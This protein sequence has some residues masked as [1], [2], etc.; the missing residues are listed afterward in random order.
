MLIVSSISIIPYL[1]NK[2]LFLLSNK[3]IGILG[4]G[5]LGRMLI[6]QG[7]NYGMQTYVL[8]KDEDAP[9]VDICTKFHRGNLLDEETVFTFGAS[10]DAI[11]I[12][13]EHVNVEALVLLEQLGKMVIPSSN[14][15]S[16]IKNK[17]LQKQFYREK[18]IPTADFR[19]IANRAELLENEDFFPAFLKLNELGYDGKGVMPIRSEAD[20]IDA[21]DQPALLEKFVDFD[22][23]I[24]VIVVRN[25]V[26]EMVVYPVVECV[27]N[28]VYNL[29]DYLISPARITEEL[30][31]KAQKIAL[32]VVEGLRSPGIFAVEMFLQ[33]DGTILVNETAPRAH[34]SGHQTI[35]G[36]FSSQFDQQARLL[37]GLPFGSTALKSMS[38]MINLV[39]E[40]GYTGI[41]VYEGLEEVMK[42]EG[43]FLHLYGKTETRPGR[44]M[45]HITIVGTKYEDLIEKA[46]FIRQHLKIKA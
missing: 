18:N 16:I 5:Q 35:E 22:K 11:I 29:V 31:V 36:N 28:P 15:L 6:Q 10:L 25:F 19:W 12:E 24:S 4:G 26:G 14:A 46:N 33:N 30:Q 21:F 3:K 37:L 8:D 43:L 42:M 20:C 1:C 13:I 7:L 17:S 34:N 9:C 23:E 39:G 44:K 41:A 27:F 38:L 45:G 40:S 32:Q 2:L